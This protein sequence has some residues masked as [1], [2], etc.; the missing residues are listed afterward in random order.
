MNIQLFQK[1]FTP[2]VLTPTEEEITNK[3]ETKIKRARA[4]HGR[5]FKCQIHAPRLTEKSRALQEIEEKAAK[6]Q[7]QRG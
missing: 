7:Q 2:S 4:I 6:I 3:L 5:E 1:K